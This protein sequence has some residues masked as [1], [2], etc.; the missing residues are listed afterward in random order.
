MDR[1]AGTGQQCGTA[2][3]GELRQNSQNRRV[4]K[5]QPGYD[6][7]DRTTGTERAGWLGSRDRVTWTDKLWQDSHTINLDR[8]VS[9]DMSGQPSRRGRQS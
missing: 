9:L 5:E 1:E 3:A 6:I 7:L 8:E 2:K 4:R